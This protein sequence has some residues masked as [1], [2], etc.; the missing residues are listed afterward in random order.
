MAHENKIVAVVKDAAANDARDAEAAVRQ[1]LAWIGEDPAREGLRD[2]PQRMLRAWREMFRGYREDPA[3]HLRTTFHET[4]DYAGPVMVQNL[5]VETCCE[6]HLLPFAGTA[7]IA[8]VPNGRVVGLSKLARVLEGY[9]KRLQIQE[10]LTAQVAW[11]IWDELAPH[12][13]AVAI[14]A[15]HCCMG[16]R[17]VRQSGAQMLTT[18]FHGV[19]ETDA[20]LRCEFMAAAQGAN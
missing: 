16:M 3:Q 2:T 17:G 5:R 7:S 4:A 15:A 1:L 8:Y 6:H 13:V 14:R 11:A 20:A 12:G 9:A 19:Y 10:R 18:S